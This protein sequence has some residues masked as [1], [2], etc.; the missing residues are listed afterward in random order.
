MTQRTSVSAIIPIV[1]ALALLK[2]AVWPALSWWWVFSPVL[3]TVAMVLILAAYVALIFV[4][5]AIVKVF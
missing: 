4:L 3:L 5:A 2:L 1:I